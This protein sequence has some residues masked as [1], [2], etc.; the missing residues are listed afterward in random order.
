MCQR[1][2]E[3]DTTQVDM[4]VRI[5][6]DHVHIAIIA[7]SD[8][9][10][11]VHVRPVRLACS[12][13]AA[14]AWGS[15]ACVFEDVG[16]RRISPDVGACCAITWQQHTIYYSAWSRRMAL[17]RSTSTTPNAITR[18]WLVIVCGRPGAGD[19]HRLAPWLAVFAD[20]R[21]VALLSWEGCG[22]VGASVLWEPGQPAHNH[23]AC[24]P[25]SSIVLGA[26]SLAR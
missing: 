18:L 19:V 26:V 21:P 17:R 2:Q 22:E 5:A 9:E 7:G 25:S 8:D 10:A 15:S 13:L 1:P 20:D 12:T 24:V 4:G 16:A 11:G 3:E 23:K 6:R 14:R